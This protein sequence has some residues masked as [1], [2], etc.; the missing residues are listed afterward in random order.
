V[1]GVVVNVC[2]LEEREQHVDVEQR[3]W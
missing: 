2:G 3:H 1:G